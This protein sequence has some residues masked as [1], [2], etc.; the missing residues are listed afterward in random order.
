MKESTRIDLGFHAGGGLS[1]PRELSLARLGYHFSKS[2]RS[3]PSSV[4]VR[5]CSHGFRVSHGKIAQTE[6]MGHHNRAGRRMA[7][8]PRAR[9]TLPCLNALSTP[10]LT[11]LRIRAC[12]EKLARRSQRAPAILKPV[13]C[14]AA[15][16]TRRSYLADGP[17]PCVA[18]RATIQPRPQCSIAI[19]SSTALICAGRR[20]SMGARAGHTF[21]MSAGR[22]LRGP[23]PNAGPMAHV[24]RFS[25]VYF[26]IHLAGAVLQAA[27]IGRL[28]GE[29]EH[30]H[31]G[32]AAPTGYELAFDQFLG[33][34]WPRRRIRRG[35]LRRRP[36]SHFD[37][38]H[39]FKSQGFED[40][41]AAASCNTCAPTDPAPHAERRT[42]SHKTGVASRQRRWVVTGSRP[43]CQGHWRHY[44][45]DDFRSWFLAQRF[46]PVRCEYEANSI[47]SAQRNGSS[48]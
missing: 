15:P 36:G 18:P 30:R 4:R 21:R 27:R 6:P 16:P 11:R 34:R 25:R 20:R 43:A 10:R 13:F 12:R 19:R 31:H 46:Y 24:S 7:A 33:L 38:S 32:P 1:G 2:G 23:P 48:E 45:C 35:R 47:R 26:A 28:R 9:S 40:R 39:Q 17:T 44:G 37:P 42:P 41:S 8:R 22:S 29:D 5:V 14:S 3:M